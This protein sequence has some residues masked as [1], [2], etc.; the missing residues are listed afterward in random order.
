MGTEAKKEE[1]AK[2][3]RFFAHKTIPDLA[4]GVLNKWFGKFSIPEKTEGFDD[5][6]FEWDDDEA[7]KAY[8][9]KWVRDK[10]KT[11]KVDNLVPGEWFRDTFKAFGAQFA[12]WQAKQK[13]YKA[14]AAGKADANKKKAEE[15]S[16]SVAEGDISS[17]ADVADVG[18]GEPLFKDFD[19][20][21]WALL[22]LRF[23]LFAMVEAFAKDVNDA[24]RPGIPEGHVG[25][26]YGKYYKKNL[27]FKSF[28]ADGLE[29]LL[30]LIKDTVCLD[31]EHLGKVLSCEA[32]DFAAL[33]KQ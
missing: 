27:S 8:L 9:Q 15:S 13:E 6:R 10:K 32:D 2:K 22:H 23:D 30:K 14:S 21:D 4:Q 18:G 17:I 31:G 1:E 20:E 5:V 7:S 11:T 29:G 19:F 3:Q 16:A 28:S 24:D 33:V 25:F 26:Y 12:A